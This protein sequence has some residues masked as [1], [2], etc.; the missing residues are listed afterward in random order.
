M[1][2]LHGTAREQG[3]YMP[4]QWMLHESTILAFPFGE[5]KW[6]GGLAKVRCEFMAFLQ[7][8][9]EDEESIILVVTPMEEES[10]KEAQRIV[11][12]NLVNLTNLHVVILPLD[13]VWMRDIVTIQLMS[14]DLKQLI[15]IK[16]K[17]NGWGEKFSYDHDCTVGYQLIEL[18]G[19]NNFFD[20]PIILEGGAVE[21]DGKGNG[22]TTR[23]CLL[24]PNRSG[25]NEKEFSQIIKDFF[26]L[27]K[28]VWLDE[29]LVGD[30]TDGH[31]DM[32]ARFTP[33]G[34]ILINQ[35]HDRDNPHF[36]VL[37]KNYKQLSHEFG[38]S[39]L[40][41]LPLPEQTIEH[42]VTN[43]LTE[44]ACANYANFYITN[45]SVIIPAFN[46]PADEKA[47]SIAA[48][49]FPKHEVVSLLAR[50]ILKYGGGLL[51]C[52]TQQVPQRKTE[53]R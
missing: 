20:V 7:Q 43:N 42:A 31:I 23:S 49:C 41:C 35:T 29:G 6:Q 16:W 32:V 14:E 27:N 48:N 38:S 44:L 34:N 12:Q 50:D 46:D 13:D 9:M 40:I 3:Y 1:R 4:A 45:H 25:L 52:L 22:I 24:N 36:H 53:T 11:K 51:N 17:F 39:S 15:P 19:I 26:G 47:R 8:I 10:F 28:L 5:E 33:T 18:M 37:E 2:R 21:V 30:H